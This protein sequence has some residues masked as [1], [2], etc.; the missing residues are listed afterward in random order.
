MWHPNLQCIGTACLLLCAAA[1]LAKG[2]PTNAPLALASFGLPDQYGAEHKLL[3]PAAN[4]TVITVA[5]KKGSEQ[6]DAWVAPLA[7]HYGERIAIVGIADVSKV[8]RLFRATVQ[9]RFKKRWTHPVMLDW[10]G[11]VVRGFNYCPDEANIF[12]IDRQGRVT[13]RFSGATNEASL[14]ALLKAVDLALLGAT[15]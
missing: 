12:V 3:F 6:V 15:Q 10:D 11:T 4:V 8:P 1:G 9:K 14:R 13:G 7:E 5:D 2:A